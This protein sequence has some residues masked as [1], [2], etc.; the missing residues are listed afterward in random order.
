MMCI[1]LLVVLLAPVT[2]QASRPAVAATGTLRWSQNNWSGGTGHRSW[3][4]NSNGYWTAKNPENLALDSGNLTLK[5]GIQSNTW[6]TTGELD[7]PGSRDVISIGGKSYLMGSF[8]YSKV[9]DI[10]GTSSRDIWAVINQVTDNAYPLASHW[11]GSSWKEYPLSFLLN[12]GHEW[13]DTGNCRMGGLYCQ[14]S[15]NVW[16]AGSSKD[17][18]TLLNFDGTAWRKVRT[19]SGSGFTAIEGT[20]TNDI[21]ASGPANYGDNLLFHFDGDDWVRYSGDLGGVRGFEF[22]SAV[23]SREIYG[24]VSG[25]LFRCNGAT[26]SELSAGGPEFTDMLAPSPGV[27]YGVKHLD[28]N[29]YRFNGGAW[30]SCLVGDWLEGSVGYVSLERA[31]GGSIV[32]CGQVR[33]GPADFQTILTDYDG[34]T[35]SSRVSGVRTALPVSTYRDN[36]GSI[37]IGDGGVSLSSSDILQLGGSVYRSTPS[38]FDV[39]RDA[40]CDQNQ[41]WDPA[42]GNLRRLA[43]TPAESMGNEYIKVNDGTGAHI[44]AVGPVNARDST[45]QAEFGSQPARAYRYDEDGDTWS[46]KSSA[47]CSVWTWRG[48]LNMGIQGRR[49]AVAS[50]KIHVTAG[51]LAGYED[52]LSPGNWRSLE[53]FVD[54]TGVG[55]ADAW[56]L[57]SSGYIWRRNGVRWTPV[58]RCVQTAGHS[59]PGGIQAVAADCAWALW[60]AQLYRYNG[61]VWTLQEDL[62]SYLEGSAPASVSLSALDSTHAFVAITDGNHD[63]RVFRVGGGDTQ[64]VGQTIRVYTT[65]GMRALAAASSDDL[66]L[67]AGNRLYRYEGSAWEPLEDSPEGIRQIRFTSPAEGYAVSDNGAFAFDG[68]VW[69]IL[70]AGGRQIDDFCCSAGGF[71]YFRDSGRGALYR[72]SAGI[73][74]DIFAGFPNGGNNSGE[75][76]FLAFSDDQMIAVGSRESASSWNGSYWTQDR[77]QYAY[78]YAYDAVADTYEYDLPPIPYPES[79]TGATVFTK[80]GP[81]G[82]IY[83]IIA[84]PYDANPHVAAYD[85]QGRTWQQESGH[86]GDLPQAP[87]GF[88]QRVRYGHMLE[89][90]RDQDSICIMGERTNQTDRR[91]YTFNMRTHEWSEKRMSDGSCR[92]G[93]MSYMDEAG[94]IFTFGGVD[95]QYGVVKSDINEWLAA[96]V[97]HGD[98]AIESSVLDLARSDF[99]IKK[100]GI[101]LNAALPGGALNEVSLWVRTGNTNNPYADKP[102]KNGWTNWA[103]VTSAFPKFDCDRYVQY[104]IALTTE[105][106][107]KVPLVKSIA[108]TF[109]A[110]VEVKRYYLAEGCTR[111]EGGNTFVTYVLIMNPSVNQDAKVK[112][113]FMANGKPKVEVPD[114]V[115]PRSSRQTIRVDDV[116]GLN[117]EEVSVM[118]ES[119]NGVDIAV[120][121]AM[122][123]SHAGRVGSSESVA[124]AETASEWQ[125]AEGCSRLGFDTYVCLQNPGDVDATVKV[126]CMR[127]NGE[128][129]DVTVTVPAMSR[130]TVDCG[131]AFGRQASHH[132]PDPQRYD[133]S[134]RVSS[135]KQKIVAERAMYF[136]YQKNSSPRVITGGHTSMGITKAASTWYV[137]EGTCRVDFDTYICIQN[138][139]NENVEA[140]MTYMKAEGNPKEKVLKLGPTSRLTVSCGMDLGWA[141]DPAHDFSVKV[142]CSGGKGLVVERAT[143]FDHDF[144]NGILISE[145]TNSVGAASPGNKWCVPE[146]C[147]YVADEDTNKLNTYVLIQN[148]N[149][150]A[151]TCSVSYLGERKSAVES[152]VV[153]ANSRQ[154]L[155]MR[156]EVDEL[157]SQGIAVVVQTDAKSDTPVIV[158]QATYGFH[159]GRKAGHASLGVGSDTQDPLPK[160]HKLMGIAATGNHYWRSGSTVA[161][162]SYFNDIPKT[163]DDEGKAEKKNFKNPQIYVPYDRFLGERKANGIT[164]YTRLFKQLMAWEPDSICICFCERA[165][166]PPQTWKGWKVP[167]TPPGWRFGEFKTVIENN[168]TKYKDDN[169]RYA[170]GLDADS[171]TGEW[172]TGIREFLNEFVNQQGYG[173]YIK[174]FEVMNEPGFDYDSQGSVPV[175]EREYRLWGDCTEDY[176]ELLYEANQEIKNAYNA[177]NSGKKEADKTHPVV[178]SGSL[179]SGTGVSSPRYTT[180]DPPDGI[181]NCYNYY[182]ELLD[183]GGD[184]KLNMLNNCDALSIH[185]FQAPDD[186]TMDAPPEGYPTNPRDPQ[187]RKPSARNTWVSGYNHLRTMVDEKDPNKPLFVS[188]AGW[189]WG[190]QQDRKENTPYPPNFDMEPAL[191]ALKHSSEVNACGVAGLLRNTE[192]PGLWYW[193]DVSMAYY[194]RNPVDYYGLGVTYSDDALI[195]KFKDPKCTWVRKVGVVI[196]KDTMQ[197]DSRLWEYYVGWTT[198]TDGLK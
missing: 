97:C 11:D 78:H 59:H 103:R 98:A 147:L 80:T 48:A 158:E 47:S 148:P 198:I 32:A 104:R 133:Y 128:T 179:L 120:A 31:P 82:R 144:G 53:N 61:A 41:T 142:S 51:T 115:V 187:Y 139:R 81:D 122:Y 136:N 176:P 146:G 106:P 150:K 168:E 65:Q 92:I 25:K 186:P 93:G 22:L 13:G 45:P 113:T 74:T 89:N 138:P 151:A 100:G 130:F 19:Y 36:A 7:S 62:T 27:I 28:P 160:L 165:F 101:L 37:W 69:S 3:T 76:A 171:G 4:T 185:V 123:F 155:D 5:K 132:E 67:A 180:T 77:G 173:K 2:F 145:G 58:F 156:A 70:D 90:A 10:H 119:V 141:D 96:P 33:G 163:S 43:R 87:E 143:Y 91:L 16:L 88:G 14:S 6:I 140:T 18:A 162:V 55:M 183:M 149:N 107:D 17:G 125:F 24:Y 8:T 68:S 79:N 196:N 34:S 177:Y 174:Y 42:S 167:E 116:P 71:C 46:E 129:T 66:W 35:G 159:D 56:A 9:R 49:L 191:Y 54:V 26:W 195:D 75:K 161:D 193:N 190:E 192:C 21:W 152:C 109:T 124:T 182:R 110:P 184:P 188:S 170:T 105:S 112:C 121:R 111:D 126:Q 197:V 166:Q 85:P 60:N 29:I 134:L 20:S 12:D 172:R 1:L 52:T 99:Y 178:M 108:L 40:G 38:Q 84:D 95:A 39:V 44:Y 30:Q 94:S 135:D 137:A 64:Q 83:A 72:Y 131:N 169:A 194:D 157:N 114:I 154:T 86:G 23:N 164:V 15:D 73:W 181:Q 63:L 117:S 118:V 127:E 175:A 153:A 189:K 102:Q 57:G 50:G